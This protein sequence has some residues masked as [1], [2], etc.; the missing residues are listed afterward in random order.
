[1]NE[2]NLD[3][4][5][6]ETNASVEE[7]ASETVTNE[8]P[9]KVA[10]PAPEA[11]PAKEVVEEV[12]EEIKEEVKEPAPEETAGE[13]VFEGT[14][15]AKEEPTTE[16]PAEP[17]TEAPATGEVP[18]EK[19]SGGK[20]KIVIPAMILLILCA[21]AIG[22]VFLSQN[23]KTVFHKFFT[24]VQS[25]VKNNEYLNSE[26]KVKGQTEFTISS[27][28]EGFD[29][30][31]TDKKQILTYGFDASKHTLEFGVA[32]ESTDNTGLVAFV[33]DNHA[34][35]KLNKADKTVLLDKSQSFGQYA[36]ML[37][38]AVNTN[39]ISNQDAVYLIDKTISLIDTSMMDGKY[40]KGKET[41]Q[42]GKNKVKLNE[43]TYKID[44]DVVV[45]QGNA[46]LKGLKND[47]K[48]KEIINSLLKAQNMTIDDMEEIKAEDIDEMDPVKFSVF[49]KGLQATFAG[50]KLEIDKN[51]LVY[52][53]SNGEFVINSTGDNGGFNITS[54]KSGNKDV[55]TGVLK[56]SD[57]SDQGK[58]EATVNECSKGKLDFDYKVSMGTQNLS[59]KVNV[60]GTDKSSKFNASVKIDKNTI[61]VKGTNKMVNG[62]VANYSTSTT[63]MNDLEIML[64]GANELQGTY[65]ANFIALQQAQQMQTQGAEQAQAQAQAQAQLQAQ[66]QAQLQDQLTP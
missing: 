52:A 11:E 40:S 21:A 38:Q 32:G 23:P 13:K 31:F 9:I 53:T 28:L 33:K 1:M 18:V 8:P 45:S 22:F 34:Y 24:T 19:K 30:V 48:A 61:T 43:Y 37:V 41:V 66:A 65:I 36:Q 50:V 63:E 47:D 15:T 14:E 2:E 4:K 6:E 16:T 60:T 59:G 10:E 49:T 54:V 25:N 62:E 7:T 26:N 56:G 42:I 44:K 57:G 35:L 3:K 20:G 64:Y 51:E 5:V 12:K 46:V 29:K 27:D 58:I 17:S 39:T 55:I